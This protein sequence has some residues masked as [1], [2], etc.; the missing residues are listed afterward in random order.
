MYDISS[1]LCCSYVL[2]ELA[3]RP[4]Y[5]QPLLDEVEEVIKQEGWEMTTVHK[6]RKLDSFIKDSLRL[7]GFSVRKC[8]FWNAP[9]FSTHFLTFPVIM[10]RK[11]LKDFTFS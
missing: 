4:E 5:V 1:S 6:L 7:S 9:H 2:Y 10:Q 11:A 8:T 3:T